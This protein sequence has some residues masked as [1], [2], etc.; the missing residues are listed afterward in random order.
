MNIKLLHIPIQQV[1][2]ADLINP[3]SIS[4]NYPKKTMR[5]YSMYSNPYGDGYE[6]TIKDEYEDIKLNINYDTMVN[7][8]RP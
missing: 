3:Y 4:N 6:V 8:V 5:I 1:E 2:P 7:V